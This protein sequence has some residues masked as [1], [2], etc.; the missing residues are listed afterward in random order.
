MQFVIT[1]KQYEQALSNGVKNPLEPGSYRGIR[2]G[3]TSRVVNTETGETFSRR[4]RENTL[5]GFY[6]SSVKKVEDFHRWK[7]YETKDYSVAM[8]FIKTLKPDASIMIVVCGTML[9]GWS[10]LEPGEY[11]CRTVLASTRNEDVSG[12]RLQNMERLIN[13]KFANITSFSII[14]KPIEGTGEYRRK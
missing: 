8:K 10:D 3:N 5:R 4:K 2:I 13:N 7:R 6:I 12:R 9:E 14:T 1:G 11:G